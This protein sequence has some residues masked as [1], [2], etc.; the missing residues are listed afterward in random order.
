MSGSARVLMIAQRYRPSIGGIE[1]H[2]EAISKRLAQRGIE[3]TVLTSSHLGGLPRSNRED[4]VRVIRIPFGWDRNPTLVYLW[5]LKNRKILSNYDIVH[6]H[7]ALPMLLWYLPLIVI[8]RRVPVFAT[9]HGYER[10]PIPSV[11][12]TL[13]RI[14][15]FFVRGAICIGHFIP[16][17]YG[18]RCDVV[19][20]GA[21]DCPSLEETPRTGAVFV[22]RLE[23]DT[24]LVEYIEAL[25]IL[26]ETL[27]ISLSLTV[28]GAGRMEEKA[29][30][31]AESFGIDAEFLGVVDNPKS[32]MNTKQVC[33]AAGYLSMLEAMSLGLPVIGIARS[34]LRAAYLRG[35]LGDGGPISIQTTPEGVA[36]EIA[37]LIENPQLAQTISIRGREFAG[38]MSWKRMVR[39]YLDLWA[40][41]SG[42]SEV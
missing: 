38:S 30:G 36:E 39:A 11:F 19:R 5:V 31:M 7:D 23:W 2:L 21:V 34:S 42:A 1:R 4:G 40:G 9:F 32:V 17:I 10:D 3:I 27:G 33:L 15:E 8:R 29:F 20:T 13:R 25:K 16:K 12:K 6:V 41:V 35:I 14:A 22:G 37:R 18:T 26:K 28:C 24:G